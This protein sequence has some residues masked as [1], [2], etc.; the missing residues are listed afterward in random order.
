MRGLQIWSRKPCISHIDCTHVNTAPVSALLLSGWY[1]R[2]QFLN[3]LL[4]STSGVLA[5]FLA[6]LWKITPVLISLRNFDCARACEESLLPLFEKPFSFRRRRLSFACSG[7]R[8]GR[9]PRFL[10]SCPALQERQL[11]GLFRT[12]TAG[13]GCFQCKRRLTAGIW[14]LRCLM[15]FLPCLSANDALPQQTI[16]RLVWGGNVVGNGGRSNCVSEFDQTNLQDLKLLITSERGPAT[17][18]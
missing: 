7:V 4:L 13:H 8:F 2:C 5:N 3:N 18:T 9:S 10:S 1:V 6:S 11:L 16:I 17:C 12:A 15:A 14:A